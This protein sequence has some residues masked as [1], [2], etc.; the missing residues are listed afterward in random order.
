VAIDVRGMALPSGHNLAEEAPDAT[1]AELMRFFRGRAQG[2]AAL[3]E[4]RLVN[5]PFG[6][7]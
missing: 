6:P 2:P 4:R 5:P 1:Y 3:Q 7:A